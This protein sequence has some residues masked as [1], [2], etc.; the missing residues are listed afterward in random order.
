MVGGGCCFGNCTNGDVELEALLFKQAL[1]I[2][3]VTF[4]GSIVKASLT[5]FIKNGHV[6]ST[7]TNMLL[8]IPAQGQRRC[9]LAR[10]IA[11]MTCKKVSKQD[12]SQ[13]GHSDAQVNDLE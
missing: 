11:R 10:I 13:Q 1:V 8:H 4:L 12:W 6:P 7:C 5:F 3:D 9:G 2:F